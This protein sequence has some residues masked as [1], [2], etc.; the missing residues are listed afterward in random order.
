MNET[1]TVQQKSDE[2]AL[3]KDLGLS[4]QVKLRELE[5]VMNG[6]PY[7]PIS[8]EGLNRLFSM[9][10]LRLLAAIRN[11]KTR[12]AAYP[13]QSFWMAL[14]FSTPAI[15]FFV[16]RHVAAV[17]HDP[18]AWLLMLCSVTVIFGVMIAQIGREERDL[19]LLQVELMIEPIEITSIRIPY[20]A[21]LRYQEAKAKGVFNTFVVAY[22]NV[23]VIEKPLSRDPAILGVKEIEP[24]ES[25]F[26]PGKRQYYMVVYWDLVKDKARAERGIRDYGKFK[27]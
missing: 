6:M 14:F 10:W 3:F 24:Y 19:D 25:R 21:A 5:E 9:R 12:W 13:F 20:G 15:L 1:K 27:V 17:T 16:A 23:S 7:H 8:M 18:G 26:T 11:E 2:L 22:P 4:G